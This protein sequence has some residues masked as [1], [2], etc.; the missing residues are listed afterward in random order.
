MP[1]A[2]RAGVRVPRWSRADTELLLRIKRE[3]GSAN[4]ETISVYFA[5]SNPQQHRSCNAIKI[6]FKSL[7]Q[8]SLAETSDT[9]VSSSLAQ[10]PRATSSGSILSNDQPQGLGL[11]TWNEEH[12]RYGE[13][14]TAC[15]QDGMSNSTANSISQSTAS[16]EAHWNPADIRSHIL[17]YPS[18]IVAYFGRPQT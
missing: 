13:F 7:M 17:P 18:E 8:S 14:P 2:S 12:K 9:P 5:A 4:W 16:T 15:T 11:Y 10:N 6:K 3:H 1:P